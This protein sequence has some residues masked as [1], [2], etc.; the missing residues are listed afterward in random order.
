M[1]QLPLYLLENHSSDPCAGIIA[2]SCVIT[3]NLEAFD[4]VI[5][6]TPMKAT[7]AILCELAKACPKGPVVF[8][9]ASLKSPIREA[10]TACRVM[11]RFRPAVYHV[12]V[13]A[14]MRGARLQVVIGCTCAART[15]DGTDIAVDTVM[16]TV[17]WLAAPEVGQ[18]RLRTRW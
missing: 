11:R 13:Y 16:F 1:H 5:L 9:V 2:V 12:Y 7:D 18:C 3:A 14:R 17:G 15:Y 8:D 10:L 4:V 6:A